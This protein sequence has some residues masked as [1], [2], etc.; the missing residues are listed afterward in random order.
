MLFCFPQMLC[1]G[2]GRALGSYVISDFHSL[3]RLASVLP[4]PR[5]A[6]VVSLPLNKLP[7]VSKKRDLSTGP[8]IRDLREQTFNFILESWKG[9]EQGH[10]A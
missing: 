1:L 2:A 7:Q 3:P 8:S 4:Q 9:R 10:Q 6:E 5:K